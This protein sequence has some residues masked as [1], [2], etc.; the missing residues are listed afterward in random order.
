[1]CHAPATAYKC[2]TCGH[3]PVVLPEMLPQLTAEDSRRAPSTTSSSNARRQRLEQR[4]ENLEKV[5]QEEREE[6]K[7]ILE[8]IVTVTQ[9]LQKNGN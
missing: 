8:Q 7:K 5:V 6:Q 3:F 1:M 4:L 2:S 9:L